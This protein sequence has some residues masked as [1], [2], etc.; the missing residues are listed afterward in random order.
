VVIPHCWSYLTGSHTSLVVIPHWWS[1]LTGSHTSLAVIPTGSQTPLAVIYTFYAFLA[2]IP[3]WWLHPTSGHTPHWRICP[4]NHCTSLNGHT[5][6]AVSGGNTSLADIWRSYLTGGHLEVIPHWR[7]SGGHT[8]LAVIWRSYL[9]G[10][11]LEV[12]PHWRSS[13][14]HTSLA[15]MPPSTRIWEGLLPLSLIIAWVVIYIFTFLNFYTKFRTFCWTARWTVTDAHLFLRVVNT[16]LTE[17]RSGL[18][19][20]PLCSI[21]IQA[22]EIE[23]I[24][25]LLF[26]LKAS[27]HNPDTSKLNEIYYWPA[28]FSKRCYSYR[29]SLRQK[30]KLSKIYMFYTFSVLPVANKESTLKYIRVFVKKYVQELPQICPWPGSRRLLT[31]PWTKISFL[32]SKNYCFMTHSRA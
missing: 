14:G 17:S 8:S 7:S 4:S 27:Y 22:Q 24:Y 18:R 31:Q 10:G 6:S 20:L 29:N 21:Q 23:T 32:I 26:C 19:I 2:V 15:V 30:L 25:I 28:G 5:S 12:I 11:H 9:S 1:Y 13:G 16:G 3:R